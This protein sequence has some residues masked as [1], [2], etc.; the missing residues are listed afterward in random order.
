MALIVMLI[1][2]GLVLLFLETLLPGLIA[3]ILGLFCLGG[4]VALA[5]TQHGPGTG[6]LVLLAVLGLLIVAV[7]LW[8]KFFP[9]S[10]MARMFVS[11]RQIGTV[12]AEQPELL[13]QIGVAQTTLRPAGAALIQGKRVDVVTEGGYIE[14]GKPVKVV[15]I[16]GLR[17]VVREI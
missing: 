16:E 6:N 11:H 5:Y 12:H 3:G 7:L 10:A 1:S 2:A 14:Q 8:L 9:E 13:D 17:V 15:A 4:A